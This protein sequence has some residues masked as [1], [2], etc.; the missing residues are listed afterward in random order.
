MNSGIQCFSNTWL[1]ARYFLEDK[2]L[3]DINTTNKLGMQ[4]RMAVSFAKLMKLLWYDNSNFV[5]PWDLKKIVGRYQTTF[6]GFSQQDRPRINTAILDALHEDLNRV[7]VKPYIEFKST[8]K[9]E[10][11]SISSDCWYGHLARNQSIVVDLMHGQYKSISKCPKCNRCSVVFDPFSMVS[12]PIPDETRVRIPFLYVPYNT[13]KKLIRCAVIAEKTDSVLTFREIVGKLLGIPKFSFI[14]GVGSSNTFDRFICK[15]RQVKLINKMC[16]K[17]HFTL[18]A[19][20][21]NPQ[22]FSVQKI[23]GSK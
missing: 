6:S 22:Y 19:L 10:D 2:Y 1:L 13:S 11:D 3:K 21:I 16:T 14:L 12:I 9:P 7:S 17:F 4:G 20:E 18:C 5:S 23:L 8:D 15:D